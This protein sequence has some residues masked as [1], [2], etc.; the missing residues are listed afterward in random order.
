MNGRGMRMCLVGLGLIAAAPAVA[1]PVPT[2]T[3]TTV[4]VSGATP[5]GQVVVFSVA[6]EEAS[7]VP[8]FRRRDAVLA[9]EDGDGAVTLD[10]GSTVP[11]RSIWVVVDAATGAAA[12]ATPTADYPLR[13]VG[14]ADAGFRLAPSTRIEMARAWIEGLVVRP[15]VG[16]WRFTAGDGAEGDADLTYDGTSRV[17]L[18][19]TEAV[20]GFVASPPASFGRNDLLFLIDPNRMEIYRTRIEVA[21]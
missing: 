12:V 16:A 3:A 9:D 10:L 8:T 11:W 18:G 2:F 13:E 21:P 20:E 19:Q 6:Q 17:E 7:Y 5:G 4:E 15:G 14:A 1:E